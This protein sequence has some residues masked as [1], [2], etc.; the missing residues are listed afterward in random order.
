MSFAKVESNHLECV[1]LMRSPMGGL[2]GHSPY[3][4]KSSPFETESSLSSNSSLFFNISSL[5]FSFLAII[6]SLVGL[7]FFFPTAFLATAMGIALMTILLW[8]WRASAGR[9]CLPGVCPPRRVNVG[10]RTSHDWI[11]QS[12]VM[13]QLWCP[14][15]FV[16]C[17]TKLQRSVDMC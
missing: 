1:A 6:P 8:G 16:Y 11:G 2:G 5:I 15:K 17:C 13:M 7:G 4:E 3:H 12:G 10:F 14:L 9:R